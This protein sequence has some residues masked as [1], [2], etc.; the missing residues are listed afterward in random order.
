MEEENPQKFN[1]RHR[2]DLNP[3][4]TYAHGECKRRDD[5][6]ADS[7]TK[8]RGNEGKI[9]YTHLPAEMTVAAAGDGVLDVD[10]V[11]RTKFVMFAGGV[12]VRGLFTT[13]ARAPVTLV[14]GIGGGHGSLKDDTP[15]RI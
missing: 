14:A 7:T 9:S 10:P 1:V 15:G 8:S 5:S 12:G 11:F 2:W 13:V 4:R 6:L 3:G